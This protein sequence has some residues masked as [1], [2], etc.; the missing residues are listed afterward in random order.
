MTLST[1]I[2]KRE[3]AT[4]TVATPATH[5]GVKAGTVANVASVAVANQLLAEEEAAIR[6]WLAY[7]KETDPAEIAWVLA[8]CADNL[9]ARAYCLEQ[10]R[11]MHQNRVS[12]D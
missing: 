3:N 12:E 6:V 1:L 8:K 7:I 11:Q 2:R 9:D 5:K 10:A 4:A